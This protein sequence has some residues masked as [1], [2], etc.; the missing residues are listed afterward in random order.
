MAQ[1]RGGDSGSTARC[2]GCYTGRVESADT[3]SCVGMNK[4]QSLQ[5]KEKPSVLLSLPQK[6]SVHTGSLHFDI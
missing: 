4:K 6:S 2:H 3:D 1:C 5:N